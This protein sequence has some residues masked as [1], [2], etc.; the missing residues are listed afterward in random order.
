MEREAW[1]AIVCGV[2]KNRT[3]LSN[4]ACTQECYSLRMIREGEW[5]NCILE[6]LRMWIWVQHLS[7]SSQRWAQQAE[8]K[9]FICRPYDKKSKHQWRIKYQ[10]R[11]SFYRG[12][13]QNHFLLEMPKKLIHIECI[14]TKKMCVFVCVCVC[15]CVCVAGHRERVTLLW[16]LWKKRPNKAKGEP[17]ALDSDKPVS[18]SV[19]KILFYPV[20]RRIKWGDKWL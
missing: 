15:V 7:L 20:V 17:M 3:W 5:W 2:T 18:S 11:R 13:M 16:P 19:K 9:P 10:E 6:D 12:K 1:Q 8:M 4:W 14:L